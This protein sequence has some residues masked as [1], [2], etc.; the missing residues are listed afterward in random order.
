MI[1]RTTLHHFS[2]FIWIFFIKNKES[3]HLSLEIW[4]NKIVK[5]VKIV[6]ISLRS[7]SH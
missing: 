7:L 2:S 6:N 4:N 5:V 3:S 1:N